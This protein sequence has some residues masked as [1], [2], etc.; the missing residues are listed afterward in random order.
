LPDILGTDGFE[1]DFLNVQNI[2]GLSAM[3]LSPNGFV[4]RSKR[5]VD[6]VSYERSKFYR[7]LMRPY[8]YH[9]FMNLKLDARNDRSAQMTFVIPADPAAEAAIH[10]ALFETLRLLAPHA[11]RALK[12][13]RN[14]IQ[15]VHEKVGV[16]SVAELSEALSVFRT[17]GAV[18]DGR[19]PA[20]LGPTQA[21][22]GA[23]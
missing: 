17:V 18:F 15:A 12:T 23:V 13:V 20:L 19:D 4:G 22:A 5:Y 21:G 7:T 1:V 3:L 16:T 14:Q 11:V 2:G 10:D 9:H 6:P 8:G